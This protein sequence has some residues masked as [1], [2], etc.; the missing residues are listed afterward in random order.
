MLEGLLVG[1]STDLNMVKAAYVGTMVHK[2]FEAFALGSSLVGAGFWDTTRPGGRRRFYVLTGVYVFITLASI[3]I[4]MALSTKFSEE[5]VFIAVLIALTAGSFMYIGAFEF[6][7]GELEKMRMLRLPV[8]PV[9]V[10][11][12]A[13]YALMNA[14]F[15]FAPTHSH[16]HDHGAYTES[17]DEHAGHDHGQDEGDDAHAGHDHF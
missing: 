16:E 15:K 17:Y 4:G 1:S 13:G 7:P 10:S 11:L 2:I 5:S 14:L 12:G 8:V 3:G 6:I 9:V